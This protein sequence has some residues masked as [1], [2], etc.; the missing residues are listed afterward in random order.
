MASADVR[1]QAVLCGMRYAEQQALP[2]RLPPHT[3][4]VAQTYTITT[5]NTTTTNGPLPPAPSGPSASPVPL[6][7]GGQNIGRVCCQARGASCQEFVSPGPCVTQQT[8]QSSHCCHNGFESHTHHTSALDGHDP[9]ASYLVG[10][11][12]LL[13]CSVSK[14]YVA[15]VILSAWDLQVDCPCTP[16]LSTQSRIPALTSTSMSGD[17]LPPL[18]DDEDEA[19]SCPSLD[20]SSD[21]DGDGL[22]DGERRI[23]P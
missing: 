5:T 10:E 9:T 19:S 22:E 2:A 8:I 6:G 15:E 20:M 14:R 1:F 23:R 4:C 7:G 21:D 13:P 16:A 11:G 18:T 17:D 12:I 3:H